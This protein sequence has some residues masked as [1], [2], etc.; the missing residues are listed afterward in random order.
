[1]KKIL[2]ASLVAVMAVTAAN[3]DIASVEYV[4]EKTGFVAEN[5]NLTTAVNAL[6]GRVST[7]EGK[8]DKDT[9]YSAGTNISLDGTTFNV[10]NGTTTAK[11]VVQLED[12]Y[13][14]ANKSDS[15][16]ATTNAAVTAALG[17]LGAL[18]TKDTVSNADL[19]SGLQAA[20]SA[21][22]SA[23]QP[24]TLT[25][26]LNSYVTS[27]ALGQ[28]DYASKAEAQGYATTAETNAKNAI[29]KANFVVKKNATDT[30]KTFNANATEDVELNLGLATVAT[31]GSYNDLSNKPTLG[32]LAA[33][34]EVAEADLADALANKIDGKQD[35]ALV[36]SS[37]EVTNSSAQYPSVAY[38][39]T[40][41]NASKTDLSDSKQDKFVAGDFLEFTT[42]DEGNSVLETTYT[43]E[44]N[45]VSI[46][47]TGEIGVAASGIT[48]AKI[49]N[50]AVTS[51]KIK[52]GAIS[53]VH[54]DIA[55]ACE[56]GATCALVIK[57]G[58]W[59]WQTVQG[60]SAGN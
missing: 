15:S 4:G 32:T 51:D 27:E 48:T 6:A 24:N 25:T 42:D 23:V 43:G 17:K 14:D 39:E 38:T 11:G 30:G 19:D 9:T 1:M 29:G 59:S 44:A 57:D 41:I 8:T 52:E 34:S 58:V 47:S 35:A 13:T 46:S 40:L 7:E 3:A 31:S 16:K 21:A 18:A 37:A 53:S 22:N 26:T 49:A 54:F 20:V 5:G 33:K 55:T 45:V 56:A 50:D 36:N 2:T 28:K 10:A 60:L 12:T